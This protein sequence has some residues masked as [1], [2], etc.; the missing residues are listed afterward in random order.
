MQSEINTY[1]LHNTDQD[2]TSFSIKT[3]EELFRLK[4]GQPEPPHRHDYYT[5]ILINKAEG[6]HSIDF[7]TYT[8]TFNTLFFIQPGQVHQVVLT[9]EPKGWIIT[10][11]ED[12][13]L[14]GGISCQMLKDIY[15]FNHYAD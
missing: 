13:L 9:Q 8:L 2:I 1:Q 11:T 12:F 7:K 14:Q 5:I 3:M 4:E 10:F 6:S 15:L